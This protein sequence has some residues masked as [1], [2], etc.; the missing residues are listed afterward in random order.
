MFADRR[1]NFDDKRLLLAKHLAPFRTWSYEALVAEI[2]RTRKAHDCLHHTDGVFDDG[3]EFHME[4]NVVWDDKPGCNVRVFAEIAT[5]PQRPMFGFIP[6]F[7]PDAM[8]S[9]IMA[10][11]GTF[12]GE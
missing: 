8:D 3:T 9:F 11:D 5:T 12:V 10:P 1:M 7:T 2:D 6:V 4:F